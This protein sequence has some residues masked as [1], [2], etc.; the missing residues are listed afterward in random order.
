MIWISHT[1]AAVDVLI[2]RNGIVLVVNSYRRSLR[3]A[4]ALPGIF[5]HT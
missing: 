2:P 1:L 4:M 3:V 5:W